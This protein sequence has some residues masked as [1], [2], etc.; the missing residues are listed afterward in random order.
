[1]NDDEFIFNLLIVGGMWVALALGVG[2]V[3]TAVRTA[4][5]WPALTRTVTRLTLGPTRVSLPVK[6]VLVI[7]VL[8]APIIVA[9]FMPIVL[10]PVLSAWCL[11]FSRRY[12]RRVYRRIQDYQNSG[13]KPSRNNRNLPRSVTRHDWE[14]PSYRELVRQYEEAYGDP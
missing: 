3:I 10:I 6:S 12:L 2:M 8:I 5:L 13:H 9:V 14:Y 11:P 4:L 7:V 1:M